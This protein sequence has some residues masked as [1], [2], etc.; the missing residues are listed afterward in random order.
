MRVP[1]KQPMKTLGTFG[2]P[3]VCVLGHVVLCSG[4]MWGLR[5]SAGQVGKVGAA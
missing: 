3:E 2:L 4:C 5:S 1:P